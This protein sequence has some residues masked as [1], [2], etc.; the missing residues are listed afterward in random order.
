M[1]CTSVVAAPRRRAATPRRCDFSERAQAPA[2][3]PGFLPRPIGHTA[4]AIPAAKQYVRTCVPFMAS[5]A[6]SGAGPTAR[7]AR[8]CPQHPNRR[9]P[10]TAP[11]QLCASLTACDG[12]MPAVRGVCSGAR[13]QPLLPGLPAP[14]PWRTVDASSSCTLPLNPARPASERAGALESPAA[15]RR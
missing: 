8:R 6:S 14:T 3:G 7:S 2:R 15:S 10:R 9:S 12:S 11:D 1:V 5:A 4:G 13:E